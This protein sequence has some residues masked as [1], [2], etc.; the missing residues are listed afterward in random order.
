MWKFFASESDS[1]WY[2]TEKLNDQQSPNVNMMVHRHR[3]VKNKKTLLNRN[4]F[5]IG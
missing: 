2:E 5:Y 3:R 1:N 4:Y